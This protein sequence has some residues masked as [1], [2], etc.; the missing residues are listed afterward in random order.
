[1][2]GRSEF[3]EKYFEV[4][5]EL[6]TRGFSVAMMDWRGQGLSERLLPVH[7]KGHITDFGAYRADL[8]SF[9]EDYAVKKFPG[10]YLLMTHSMGGVPA[11]QL[12]ADGYDRFNAAVLCAPMTQLF[13]SAVKRGIVKGIAELA[14]R[15]GG[16]RRSIPGVKEHSIDFDGNVLTSDKIRHNRF[17]ELQAVAPNA[18]IREPTYG[19]MKAAVDAMEDLHKPGRFEALKT[20][21][22]IISAEDDQL[23]DSDDHA[24]I[25]E[26]SRLIDRVVIDGAL[27]EIL[28]EQDTFRVAYWDAFDAFV[29][30][31][32][33]AH[34]PQIVADDKVERS[35]PA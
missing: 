32:V 23:V 14:C 20:P 33:A 7:E 4:I 34:E 21:V 17:R 24:T 5:S 31:L 8:C 2:S 22:R 35:S 13:S 25:A 18:I 29:E 11:L 26:Q 12:L 15:L 10:P 9:T 27:H 16:A 6:Q 3:I 19:W 1:M 30:P 28:M